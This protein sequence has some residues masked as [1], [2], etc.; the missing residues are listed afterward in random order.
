MLK[1]R[2]IRAEKNELRRRMKKFR[3]E[4]PAAVKQKKDDA[5]RRGIQALGQYQACE[6]LLTFVSTP[7]EVDTHAL[8]E[9]A[10]RSGKTVAVPYCIDGTRQ[11]DF[12]CI[13]SM[14]DLVPRTFGVLEPLIDRCPKLADTKNSVCLV[15]GLAFDRHGFRLGY[16]KGYYD[17]FLSGYTGFK[18][19][20]VYEECLCQR[21]PHGYYD[22]AVDLLVTEKRRKKPFFLPAKYSGKA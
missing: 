10:L 3:R 6:T 7:I 22:V 1:R 14:D 13:R 19:G 4:M 2:D 20:I 12:Y 15:P 16:G 8:I 18:I 5:I 11:M 17:R 9:E 21:L